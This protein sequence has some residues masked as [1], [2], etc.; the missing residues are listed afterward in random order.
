MANVPSPTTQ[1]SPTARL[2][3]DKE[4]TFMLFTEIF[5]E[6]SCGDFGIQIKNGP[7]FRCHTHILSRTGGFIGK[8]RLFGKLLSRTVEASSQVGMREY[9]KKNGY[10]RILEDL[11]GIRFSQPA[12]SNNMGKILRDLSKHEDPLRPGWTTAHFIG[13]QIG[14]VRR[15]DAFFLAERY[16]VDCECDLMVELLRFVYQGRMGF[17]DTEPQTDKDREVMSHKMLDVAYAAERYSVDALFEQML[18]WFSHDAYAAVGERNFADAFFHLQHFELRCT[19]EHSRQALVS[20]VASDMLKTRSQF[21]AVTRDHRWSSLPVDF[22][23]QVLSGDKVPIGSEIEVLNLIERWNAN[24]DKIKPDIVRLL[25][26]FRPDA[27]TRG[28]LLDWLTGM[29]WLGMDGAV[30]NMAELRGVKVLVD[31]SKLSGKKSR[32]N[33]RGAEL[34]EAERL[35]AAEKKDAELKG[36][37]SISIE[38]T[39]ATF[40]HCRGNTVLGQGCAFSMS[41]HQRLVQADVIRDPGLQRLRVVLSNPRSALWDPEHEVFVGLSFGEGR[42]FGFLCSATAYSG[43]YGLRALASAAPAPSLPVHLTGS[44]NKVEFDLA[45]EVQLIRVNTVVACKLSIIFSNENITEELFQISSE[46]L[47]YGPGL[48]YQVV[49][50]GLGNDEIHVQLS[51]VSGGL[52]QKD[53][54][55]ENADE[56]PGW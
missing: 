27:E 35:L 49:A 55:D 25:G 37:T 33:L 31:N 44:G 47:K 14:S 41:A 29:G 7:L 21:R 53:K 5:Q 2:L 13:G 51:W 54:E 34:A 18:Q 52:V 45:L 16:E 38:D 32:R 30:P 17:F 15:V 6:T 36:G 40:M 4:G 22:V 10:T 23:E 11:A 50:T 48:R 46:T 12:H 39:D 9:F 42:Y 1:S 24:A 28:I 20:T 19:E 8:V 56:D 43:I 26:C 3:A